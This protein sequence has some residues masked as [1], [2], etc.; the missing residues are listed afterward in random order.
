M[1]AGTQ[2]TRSGSE[3]YIRWN[4]RLLLIDQSGDPK[5]DALADYQE[6]ERTR[7][8]SAY[9]DYRKVRLVRVDGYFKDAADWEFLYTTDGG[10]RQ[11]AVKRNI[12]VNDHQAYS[13]SWYT[14]PED[15]DAAKAD[16]QVIYQGFRPKQ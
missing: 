5:P 10:N 11:H 13:V 12:V 9:R 4:N 14:T 7:A 2:K 8:G 6:Q 1:P 15:W 3:L 16:L